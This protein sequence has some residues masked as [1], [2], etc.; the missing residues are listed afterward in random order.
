MTHYP[1]TAILGQDQMVLALILNAIDPSLGGVLLTGPQ[2]T[3][4][5]T[6]IRSFQDV[7]PL[8]QVRSGCKFQCNPNGAQFICEFCRNH[9]NAKLIS[10][11][12]KIITI[13]LGATTDRVVGSVDLEQLIHTGKKRLIPGL[14]A[15]AHRG[16]LY[17]DEI[18]L[19]PDHLVD[20]LLDVASSGE[21]FIEREGITLAHPAEFVLIGSM[22]PEEGE[23]RPQ[24][25]DRLGLEIQ[26]KPSND[27]QIRAQISRNV[28]EF[29]TAPEKF[30]QKYHALQEK[31][32][33]QIQ[34]AHNRV[35]SIRYRGDLL[36]LL[37]K[38]IARLKLQ[39]QRYDLLLFRCARAIAAWHSHTHILHSDLHQAIALA[40][41]GKLARITTDLTL[42]DLLQTFDEIWHAIPPALND[43]AVDKKNI[44]PDNLPNTFK[45]TPN[46]HQEN[47][48][49]PL[50]EEHPEIPEVPE[51]D[52]SRE[53]S[54]DKNSSFQIDNQNNIGFK[55]GKQ[56]LN[57]DLY[58]FDSLQFSNYFP[59]SPIQVN[60]HDL[61][62]HIRKKRK[63]MDFSGK[64]SRV[65]IH[66][67]H[68]GNFIYSRI[69]TDSP[70]S[71]AFLDSIK[72]HYL[73]Y[74]HSLHRMEHIVFPS[75]LQQNP[76]LKVQ[77]T[78]SD[79]REKIYEQRAPFSF[80]FIV[81]ASASMRR[82]L[83]QT[84]KVIQSVHA[85]GYKKKD[86]VC[87]I[88][89]QGRHSKILQRPSVSFSVGLEKLHRIKATSYTPLASALEKSL[90]LINQEQIKGISIPVIVIMSDLGANISLKSPNAN[91]TTA[92]DFIQIAD[93]LVGLA[94][95]IGR[96]HY[97]VIIMKPQKSFA[98]RFLGVDPF[99]V[100]KIEKAFI[101]YC[102][103]E[104]FEYDAYD[105][106][107][108]I[109]LLNKLLD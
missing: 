78:F 79:L 3:G 13:P 57:E 39:S 69:P 90:R 51:V 101:Q 72:Q 36:P 74:P 52:S 54:Q 59:Q 80:Y 97:I 93:E 66:T 95:K 1:F 9:P 32:A 109:L 18:N 45:S 96:K 103:A 27:S 19:L 14:L 56:N 34:S 108:T 5:S 31:C 71:I 37:S 41:G 94:R 24:I 48:K 47:S 70:H 98:T 87:V 15:S 88:S 29:Q 25:A 89:F 68:D 11:S 38:F 33:Q 42:D 44:D 105:P 20:L 8:I 28:I 2:G 106:D 83:N 35:D 75:R 67:H 26:V 53:G 100:Q 61:L 99:S 40:L 60:I 107:A 76:D 77:L 92:E 73:H 30:Y 58:D 81:D 64:G 22:N 49:N 63:I 82:T 62:I 21:N 102:G 17:I 84:I 50:A 6:A 104:I 23:L 10:I 16:F 7:L 86:K 65:R 85:E 46:L 43:P 4:K 12:K 55:S 91:T